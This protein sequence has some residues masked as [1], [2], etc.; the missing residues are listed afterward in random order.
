MTSPTKGYIYSIVAA[1]FSG[2][3][4]GVGKIILT[5]GDTTTMIVGLFACAVPIN[6]IWWWTNR[7][8]NHC[9]NFNLKLIP[10]ISLQALLSVL[11]IFSLWYG[12]KIIDPTSGAF[13]SRFKYWW[14]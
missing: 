5:E 11:A 13:F 12:I 1:V 8:N 2:L 4:I 14:L 6:F 10:L 3:C 7:D 9:A